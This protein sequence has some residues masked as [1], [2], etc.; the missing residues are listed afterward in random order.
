[1]E[2]QTVNVCRCEHGEEITLGYGKV[3]TGIERDT[4]GTYNFYTRLLPVCSTRNIYSSTYG[5]SSLMLSGG[6]QYVDI[7]MEEYG[8]YDRSEQDA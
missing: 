1:M 4:T 7:H 6:R 2:G 3:L 5:H 8:I